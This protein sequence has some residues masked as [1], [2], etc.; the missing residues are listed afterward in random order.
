MADCEN[1]I[2]TLRKTFLLIAFSS[3]M[4]RGKEIW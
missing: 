4:T 3:Y 2:I 1:V